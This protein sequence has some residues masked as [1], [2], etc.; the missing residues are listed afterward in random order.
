MYTGITEVADDIFRVDTPLGERVSS[1]YV[2]RGS[3]ASAL[4][5]TGI[6]GTIPDDLMPA[7]GHLGVSADQISDVAISHC[8]VD[9]FG[10]VA[11]ARAIFTRARIGAGEGDRRA[12]EDYATWES[13]RGRS[14]LDVWGVDEPAESLAWC[15]SVIRQTS[16]DTSYV[17]G[18]VIDLGSRQI[19]VWHVPGH[20]PGHLALEAD[21]ARALIVSDAVLGESVDMA[22]GQPAFPPTYRFVD[23]YVTS[24]QRVLD[25]R[26]ELLLTAHYPTM[27]REAGEGFLQLTLDFVARL[28]AAIED[29]FGNSPSPLTLEEALLLLNPRVGAW[30]QDGTAAA[31]AFPVVGHLERWVA[32]GRLVRH[33]Q[34]SGPARW[35]AA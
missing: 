16:L 8:D 30:P 4:F 22:N 6:D 29:V 9:H 10:G 12:I 27:G 2:V 3:D 1:L 31:L 11:D 25:Y 34:Q 26:P 24:T 18:E 14:F 19:K 13:D 28:E 23:D 21:W 32:A 33:D 5:D 35:S 7:L 15:Q 17:D 20:S